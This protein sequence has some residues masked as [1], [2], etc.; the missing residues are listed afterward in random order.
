M[1]AGQPR[2]GSNG[3]W[4]MLDVRDV[5]DKVSTVSQYH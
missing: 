1:G 4:E 5:L 2:M 3:R